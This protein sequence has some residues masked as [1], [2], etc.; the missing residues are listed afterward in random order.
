MSD[1]RRTFLQSAILTAGLSGAAPAAAV[2]QPAAQP[3]PVAA[4]PPT[5]AQQLQVSRVNFFGVE[6][7][8]MVLGMNPLYGY[9]HYNNTLGA[10][11][12]E[13]YTPERV[14]E[15]MH[16]CNRFG[17]NAYNFDVPRAKGDL[18]PFRAEGARCISSSRRS[19]T[20]QRPMP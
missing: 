14:C 3:P 15:V 13:Y 20:R 19:A 9:G 12:R 8:R 4:D 11:M 10:I 5:P 7:S 16:Q 6:I 18:E 17:I 2:A 1:T